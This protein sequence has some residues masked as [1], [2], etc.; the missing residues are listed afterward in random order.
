MTSSYG[1]FGDDGIFTRIYSEP[2]LR[3]FILEAGFEI[4]GIVASPEKQMQL[5]ARK[6][7]GNA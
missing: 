3:S 5:R 4:L 6:P 2:E 1:T 7:E